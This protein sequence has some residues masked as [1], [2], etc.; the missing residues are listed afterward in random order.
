MTGRTKGEEESPLLSPF[1]LPR[2]HNP[3]ASVV[4]KYLDLATAKSEAPIDKFI[5]S[6]KQ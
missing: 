5:T 6:I 3:R 2:A 4:N 1:H